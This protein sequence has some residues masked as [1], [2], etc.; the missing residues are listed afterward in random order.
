MRI[1]EINN[2]PKISPKKERALKKSITAITK[3]FPRTFKSKQYRITTNWINEFKAHLEIHID[4]PALQRDK[5]SY[6][7]L[8]SDV[9]SILRQNENI[10]KYTYLGGADPMSPEPLFHYAVWELVFPYN[11]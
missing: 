10:S 7:F 4:S 11:L 1:N 2:T 5:K 8:V 6:N 9:E 3:E